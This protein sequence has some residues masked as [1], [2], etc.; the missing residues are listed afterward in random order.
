MFATQPLAAEERVI[1][2]RGERVVWDTVLADGEE[3]VPGTD[4]GAT[5]FFDLG[6]G[7]VIDGT[8]NG[9]S[10]R[11]INHACRPN[12]EAVDE[13]GRIYI[14]ALRDV[15]VGEELLIDY[16]LLAEDPDDPETRERYRCRCGGNGCRRTMLA[17]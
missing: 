6:D 5:Y 3:H 11:F 14:H 10:A 2:Y 9:N 15:A 8:R 16:A 1:E 12:C 4:S 7:W 13:E 17:P